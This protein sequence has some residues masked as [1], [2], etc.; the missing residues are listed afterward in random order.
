MAEIVE[1][2]KQRD[3]MCKNQKNH[4][5]GCELSSSKNTRKVSCNGLLN[6][7]PQEAE[8]IIMAWA[9]ENPI[10]TNAEKF[11]EVF[12]ITWNEAPIGNKF[13]NQEYK[14]PKEV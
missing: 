6:N 1:V 11:K 4:C 9:K 3:R 13:W 14:E 8:E 7:Y 2:I 5:E 12:G 10:K